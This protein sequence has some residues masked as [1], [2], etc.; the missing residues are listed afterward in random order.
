VQRSLFNTSLFSGVDPSLAAA[1]TKVSQHLGKDERSKS[2][3][4][5]SDILRQL[6]SIT[7]ETEVERKESGGGEKRDIAQLIGSFK[8]SNSKAG[9]IV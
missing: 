9:N 4:I 3:R 1:A 7:K 2:K 6:K 8:V 5:E